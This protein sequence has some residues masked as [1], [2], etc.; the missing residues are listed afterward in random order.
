MM[1]C[2]PLCC[3]ASVAIFPLCSPALADDDDHGHEGEHFD[4]GVWNDSGVLRTGGWDHDEEALEVPELRVFEAAFGEDPAFPYATDEPGIGG[5]AADLGL[6]VGST[7]TLNVSS[8][9]GQWNGNGFDAVVDAW[10]QVDYGPMSVDT[11]SG[12]GL[13]FLV[14]EDYDLHPI[15]S[16]DAT[17]TPATGSYLM[18]LTASMEGLQ[19]SD[20]FW[21]VF[22]LG[23][24]EEDY[25]ASVEWVEDNLV[26]APAA[27][28]VLTAM[29][30]GAVRRR[31]R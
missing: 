19:E 31:R 29:G 4:I 27:L 24:D 10:M 12:G 16:I 18:E 9:L 23:L 8:G 21:V 5:V 26:P 7:L 11:L 17:S 25:E 14:T 28:P 1:K 30:L 2:V 15:Y 13:D 6:P 22:N 3:A 20:S